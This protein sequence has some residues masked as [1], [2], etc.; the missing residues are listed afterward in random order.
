MPDNHMLQLQTLSFR[1]TAMHTPQQFLSTNEIQ[2]TDHLQMLLVHVATAV[3]LRR[4]A[5]RT[6]W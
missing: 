4:W 6:V 2:A 3:A 1:H 5:C